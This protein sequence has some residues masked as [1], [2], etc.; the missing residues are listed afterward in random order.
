MSNLKIEQVLNHSTLMDVCIVP[1]IFIHNANCEK[2]K[3]KTNVLELWK[4]LTSYKNVDALPQNW[5]CHVG[6]G[7][8]TAVL[9]APTLNT[10]KLCWHWYVETKTC[11]VP[12][13]QLCSSWI[14]QRRWWGSTAANVYIYRPRGLLL[15]A[16]RRPEPALTIYNRCLSGASLHK[17]Q[18][19]ASPPP[20]P[21]ALE[22]HFVRIVFGA[23]GEGRHYQSIL[24]LY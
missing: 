22:G 13:A 16:E 24:R 2:L 4:K 7:R 1:A 18:N 10:F 17:Y 9:H 23:A 6:K 14:E 8:N 12:T 3:T 20:P 15:S 21:S 11:Q 5:Q 19:E